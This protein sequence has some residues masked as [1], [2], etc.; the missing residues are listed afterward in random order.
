[1]ALLS[2]WL[3]VWVSAKTPETLA[4]RVQA[5]VV[6]AFASPKIKQYIDGGTGYAFSPVHSIQE[7]N[8][9]LKQSFDRNA[10]II[11]KYKIKLE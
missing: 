5:E 3:G 10:G 1:M 7:Q 9:N 6:K 4:N 2:G 11:Q 8:R